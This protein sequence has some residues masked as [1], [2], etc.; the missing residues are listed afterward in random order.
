MPKI[1]II[2]NPFL[3]AVMYDM[4]YSLPE[5]VRTGL[6]IYYRRIL[7][8]ERKTKNFCENSS[9][10]T[11]LKFFHA[12]GLSNAITI[13]PDQSK[14]GSSLKTILK[15]YDNEKLAAAQKEHATLGVYITTDRETSFLLGLMGQNIN[16]KSFLLNLD[17][18][19]TA[20]HIRQWG[21]KMETPMH[22]ELLDT[23][24][25]SN[26]VSKTILNAFLNLDATITLYGVNQNDLQIL[27]YFFTNK[28]FYISKT[29]VWDRFEGYIP[30][31]KATTSIKR[32]L[33]NEYL[34][35]NL[36][37]KVLKYTISSKGIDL[38]NM[39]I[40]KILKENNFN[41]D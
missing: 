40:K 33:L 7:V 17:F 34:N 19:K 10:D 12:I 20:Y 35:K 31:S 3:N 25:N 28:D 1:D 32:L 26:V 15:K 39:F 24:E 41:Y 8:S 2:R 14:S 23:V 11:K 6:S 5:E 37:W 18:N 22:K 9:I 21:K 29:N 27:L 38:I 30:K 4:C 36:D 13:F 16:T